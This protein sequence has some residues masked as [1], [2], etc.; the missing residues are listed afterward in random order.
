MKGSM[1]TRGKGTGGGQITYVPHHSPFLD[2]R[3]HLL[4]FVLSEGDP[5]PQ[6]PRFPRRRAGLAL[7]APRPN[8][9]DGLSCGVFAPLLPWSLETLFHSPHCPGWPLRKYPNEVWAG[10]LWKKN[11]GMMNA[12]L[13][14]VNG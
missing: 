6:H 5:Y 13:S 4:S 2:H 11:D 9:P 14:R 12:R 8:P 10:N 1:G 7:Y 3:K